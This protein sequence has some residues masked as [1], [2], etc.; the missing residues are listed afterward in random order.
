MKN[1]QWVWALV[2]ALGCGQ[3]AAINEAWPDGSGPL[4]VGAAAIEGSI[5]GRDD[6]VGS[7]SP[8]YPK[9]R[10]D[11]YTI[12]IASGPVAIGVK[13]LMEEGRSNIID[14]EIES[15]PDGNASLASGH[16]AM[17]VGGNECQTFN[18]GMWT[19][20]VLTYGGL[21]SQAQL[22][23]NTTLYKVKAESGSVCNFDT[24]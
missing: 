4:T 9:L 12:V 7:F 23:T 21:P 3:N 16:N 19:L 24:Y 20:R 10:G 6:D 5:D 18:T 1:L 11:Q 22:D 17:G 13:A 14:F 2:F 8:D 15:A